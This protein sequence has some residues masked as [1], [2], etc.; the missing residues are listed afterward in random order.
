MCGITGFYHS[1]DSPRQAQD[2]QVTLDAMTETIVHRGPD[3]KG[4]WID[5]ITGVGLGHQRLAIRD[6]S[7]TGHQPMT[8]S[9]DRYVIVYN[10]EVY[11]HQ[12]IAKD[13]IQKGRYLKGKSDTEVI[14]EACAEFGVEATVKRLIGMFAFALYDKKE[15]T[16]TLVRD[17]LGIKPLYY[18][19]FNGLLIFGSELKSLR[20]NKAWSPKMNRDAIAGLM[21]HKYIPA[22]ES[23]YQN[24]YK[25]TQGCMLK[26]NSQGEY[27]IT[28]YW[29]LR[30]QI[31]SFQTD[32]Q[33]KTE[34]EL[35]N[36]LDILLNDAV[37]RRLVSDVPLGSLLSG[38]IDS[39]LVTAL[40]AKNSEQKINTFSIGFHEPEYNEAPYAKQ[41]AEHLGTHHTELYVDSHH[42][43]DLIHELPKWYDEPFA[44]PSQIPTIMVCELVKQHA[45]VV[46]SGD[47]GDELFAGY[48]HYQRSINSWNQ[49]KHIPY[50]IRIGIAKLLGSTPKTILKNI[51]GE[52][53]GVRNQKL[54]QLLQVK[55]PDDFYRQLFS[56]WP[57][58][59]AIV[60]NAHEIHNIGNDLTLINS[61]PSFLQ[62]MMFIDTMTYLPDDILTKVDRAS[63]R[64]ALEARVPLLD[65]RLVE[66][67]FQLPD[68]MKLKGQ[69]TK[70][71]LRQILYQ[72]VPQHLI[73]RPK[74]GFGIPLNEWL[75]GPLRDWAED[76]LSEQRLKSQGLF[77]Y[78]PIRERWQAHL[79]Y[80]HFGYSLWNVLMTQA[81]I[82]ANP[83]VLI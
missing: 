45:T 44:D 3:S 63:M 70:W 4:T 15:Q 71:A 36:E 62:R 76:L 25:L 79:K 58:P 60:K 21:R 26:I 8:S 74:K 13:L 29:D 5:N 40:M 42:A 22:P 20:A 57:N 24:V 41:I 48:S 78:A 56:V 23:I 77:E 51:L 80:K 7:P 31:E 39:S 35:L 11:S 14:L 66:F 59:E 65:H 37:K 9:C 6:L 75:T 46:L 19:V 52:N 67:A 73:D 53:L 61:M 17:R 33:L 18:G 54:A 30:T 68:S 2:L 27:K 64:V 47:G 50:P 55:S 16:L 81:W 43:L 83:E 69:E 1:K 82:E 32:H 34:K 38:G 10:G 72:Y 12:E 28:P 49:I